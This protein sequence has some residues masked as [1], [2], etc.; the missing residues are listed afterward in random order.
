VWVA[1]CKSDHPDARALR[2][3]TDTQSAAE[4]A[5][6]VQI[7]KLE[8]TIPKTRQFT[9]KAKKIPVEGGGAVYE[10]SF[11]DFK[12]NRRKLGEAAAS[13]QAKRGKRAP[14]AIQP[15]EPAEPDAVESMDEE[16]EE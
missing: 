9:F 2:P 5:F 3:T 13:K 10:I 4:L 7:R 11:A 8:V 16:E 12:T 1:P 14:K 15:V 6:A